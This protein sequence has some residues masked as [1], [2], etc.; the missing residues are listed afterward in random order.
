ME[1][2]RANELRIGNYVNADLYNDDLILVES[3]CS[4]NKEIFNSTAGEIPLTSIKPIELTEEWL[5]KLGFENWGKGKLYS[6]EFES[7]DR[8]VLHNVLDGTSNFEV[9]FIKSTYGNSEHYQYIISCDEDDRINWGKEIEYVHQ[10]QN[11]YFCICGEEL[12][13]KHT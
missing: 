10:L 4:K 8:F 5:I 9:H 11:L 6:S 7:Y 2:L 1:N 12:T 3:I 13:L